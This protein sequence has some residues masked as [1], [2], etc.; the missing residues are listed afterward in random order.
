MRCFKCN[1]SN[2]FEMLYDVITKEGIIKLCDK[3]SR[4][5]DSPI[6]RKPTIFQLKE[7]ERVPTVYERLSKVAGIDTSKK[8]N[9]KPNYLINQE[10]NLRLLVDKN[11]SEKIRATTK[12]RS[13]LVNNF[14][15][16]IMRARRNRKLTQKQL[17]DLLGEPEAAIKLAEEGILPG[18][19][20]ILNK[21]ENFLKIDLSKEGK[22]SKENS[23]RNFSPDAPV[24]DLGKQDIFEKI[25]KNPS[26]LTISD[27]KDMNSQPDNKETENKKKDLSEDEIRRLIFKR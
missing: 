12:P 2:E 26:Q 22:K 17:A 25:E 27:L 15:W 18:D 20:K 4:S 3:C 19:N 9:E 1:I 13:D 23:L 10:T 5:E 21:I 16:I 8:R 24:A 14:H 6:I 7:V 11:Y